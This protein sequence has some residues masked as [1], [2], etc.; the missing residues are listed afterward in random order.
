MPKPELPVDV[1]EDVPRSKRELTRDIGGVSERSGRLKPRRSWMSCRR[2]RMN[3]A[4][5][6]ITKTWGRKPSEL[7]A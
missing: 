1:W 3:P 5:Y 6:R 2:R 7:S 4:L